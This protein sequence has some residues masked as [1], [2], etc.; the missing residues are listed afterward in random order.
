MSRHHRFGTLIAGSIFLLAL[1]LALQ[2][3]DALAWFGWHV[4]GLPFAFGGGIVDNALAVLLVV[5]VARWLARV[6][7]LSGHL[8][9]R[10]NGL[11]GPMLTALATLPF[12]VGLGLL[13][14]VSAEFAFKDLLWLAVLFPLA[15][16]VVFR[17]F[18][19][20]FAR[21]VLRWPWLAA[22]LPQ[23]LVFGA[24][25]WLSMGGGTGVALQVFAITA[26]GAMV[27]AWLDTLD[28]DTIWSGWILHVSL[29]AAWNVFAV[30]DSASTGWLGNALRFGCAA[31]AVLM[32]MALRRH[33]VRGASGLQSALS[34]P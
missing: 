28:G 26:A 27:F 33:R 7:P 19:F 22:V 12:W 8:G 20:I 25:H 30:S 3:R 1:V 9:L 2:L 29:N 18:G 34:R 5:G 13:Y 24:I 11:A 17:G 31:L 16:E 32:L 23:T 14:P 15:E 4:P 10:W 21:R 6:G